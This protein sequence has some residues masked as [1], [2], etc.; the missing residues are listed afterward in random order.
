MVPT[1]SLD[2]LTEYLAPRFGN[3]HDTSY[4]FERGKWPDELRQAVQR[5]LVEVAD[6]DLYRQALAR[7]TSRSYEQLG[8]ND[9]AQEAEAI[10]AQAGSWDVIYAFHEAAVILRPTLE[11]LITNLDS[12]DDDHDLDAALWLETHATSVVLRDLILQAPGCQ[13]PDWHFGYPGLLADDLVEVLTPVK[14]LEVWTAVNGPAPSDLTN[15]EWQ[16]VAPVLPRVFNWSD[17]IL[18][19]KSRPA[20]NGLLYKHTMRVG[21]SQVPSRYYGRNYNSL[22]QRY[23]SWRNDGVFA[24]MLDALE[25][26]PEA[27]RLVAWLRTIVD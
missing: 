5:Y 11:S 27:A 4:S 13:P 15:A 2:P 16:L 21:W 18:E 17:E 26:I 12:W 10:L 9:R 1:D 6:D 8:A 19:K 3:V 14:L 25:G 23:Y 22:Y 24:R 7:L 20:I